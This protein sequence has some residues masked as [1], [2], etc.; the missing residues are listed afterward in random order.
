MSLDR[1]SADAAER[2]FYCP[3]MCRFSCPVSHELP[4]ETLTPWGKMTQ[5][6]MTS[7]SRG[8]DREVPG[9]LESLA[10]KARKLLDGKPS[11]NLDADTAEAFYACSG[12]LRCR[13]WC[14]HDND[15]P[16]AL[17]QGRGQAVAQ[18]VA[19]AAATAVAD[20]FTRSGHARNGDPLPEVEQI[21]RAHV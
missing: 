17:Y 19:P 21:G 7:G 4:R 6:R 20:R 10:R 8:S 12:C 18:G 9:P 1:P 13:T 16:R 11:R 2:C 5:L 3:K 15:V 14:E